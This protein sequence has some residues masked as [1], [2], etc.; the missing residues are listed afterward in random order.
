MFLEEQTREKTRLKS[1]ENE[2]SKKIAVD[3]NILE[4]KAALDCCAALGFTLANTTGV[5][6]IKPPALGMK[7]VEVDFDAIVIGESHS[8]VKPKKANSRVNLGGVPDHAKAKYIP[9][10]RRREDGEPEDFIKLDAGEG[11]D[12]ETLNYNQK[13]RRKLCRA[14]KMLRYARK[15][16]FASAHWTTVAKRTSR[17]HQ[18]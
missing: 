4:R 2:E 7:R 10:G 3:I 17:S 8:N 15:C 9:T 1:I 18:S 13:L 16:W 14:S 12:F 5:D 11:Q 6:E